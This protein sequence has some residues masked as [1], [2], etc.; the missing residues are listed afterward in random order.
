MTDR[1][2][3]PTR[4]IPAGVP[5][6][7]RGPRPG[8]RPPWHYPPAPTAAQPPAPPAP[9]PVAPAPEP[10][11]VQVYVTLQPGPYF[12]PTASTRRERLWAWLTS[13]GRPGLPIPHTRDRTRIMALRKTM[14]SRDP[15][16]E[17]QHSRE[18]SASRGGHVQTEPKPVPG[19][20][21]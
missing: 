9:A 6:P 7:D 17:P 20:P 15:E 13:I 4:V 8:E 12:E 3:L 5:L 14:P 1:P 21:K 2:I 19:T 10:Q 16:R 11:P 18:Y